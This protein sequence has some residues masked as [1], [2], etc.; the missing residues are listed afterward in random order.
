MRGVISSTGAPPHCS[1]LRAYT[2]ATLSGILQFQATSRPRNAC[3]P[4]DAILLTTHE[5]NRSLCTTIRLVTAKKR[6][7]STGVM[8]RNV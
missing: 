3:V 1:D 6:A 7:S 2:R 8:V 4:P 5:K